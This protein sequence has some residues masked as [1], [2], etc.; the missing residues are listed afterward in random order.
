MPR[1]RK[2][3]AVH[4]SCGELCLQSTALHAVAVT[5]LFYCAASTGCLVCGLCLLGA[6]ICLKATAL[7]NEIHVNCLFSRN[8]SI[9]TV[10]CL[11]V[12]EYVVFM[13]VLRYS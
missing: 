4:S 6:D 5:E 2:A 3:F 13:L 1:F 8:S 10:P 9:I 7:E 12:H 11:D